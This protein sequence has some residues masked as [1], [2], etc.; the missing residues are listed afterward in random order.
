MSAETTRE[1]NHTR[2]ACSTASFLSLKKVFTFETGSPV[3]QP[4]LNL[5]SS[6][7]WLWSPA[8]PV[9]THPVLGWQTHARRLGFRSPFLVYTGSV[10]SHEKR[11]G[12]WAVSSIFSSSSFSHIS[13]NIFSF[14]E[15]EA[16]LSSC[17]CLPR[18]NQAKGYLR[19]PSTS[20]QLATSE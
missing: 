19:H 12:L 9:Q 8:P 18:E 6:W 5:L 2:P 3:A 4:V 20:D 14:T 16:S 13:Q 7:C 10:V 11:K 17:K 1:L 15:H